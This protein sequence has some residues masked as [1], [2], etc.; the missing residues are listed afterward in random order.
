MDISLLDGNFDYTFWN[1][2][3]MHE[4]LAQ[5]FSR[6]ELSTSVDAYNALNAVYHEHQ[7]YLTVFDIIAQTV[8]AVITTPIG[9]H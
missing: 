8:D 2:S 5:C 6:F 1:A 9:H 7:R 4:S 3:T